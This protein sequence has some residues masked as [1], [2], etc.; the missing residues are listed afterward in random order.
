L[1]WP[2]N[3]PG[4][5][6]NANIY[7]PGSGYS[8]VNEMPLPN[9]PGYTIVTPQP[10]LY[11]DRYGRPAVFRHVPGSRRRLYGTVWEN[12]R[13]RRI[14]ISEYQ[15]LKYRRK[16]VLN[17]KPDLD[18]R[19][20]AMQDAIKQQQRQQQ[21]LARAYAI[22]TGSFNGSRAKYA[23]TREYKDLNSQL[24]LFR[25]LE[26]TVPIGSYQRQVMNDAN[27]GP[28]GFWITRT[29]NGYIVSQVVEAGQIPPGYEGGTWIQQGEF[30]STLVAL[31]L[32]DPNEQRPVG[33]SAETGHRNTST[34][35]WVP[36]G[37]QQ[38][39]LSAIFG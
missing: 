11:K 27:P 22:Q 24:E 18:A 37:Y 32:R 35:A 20:K 28:F 39:L 2:T 1:V 5:G 25:Y 33:A 21:E 29:R 14:E 6:P 7:V 31:G 23:R 12:G 16:L 17:E 15:Y 10:I 13:A 3:G 30:A 26:R 19:R 4:E 8:L 9:E 36:S 34:G 38:G